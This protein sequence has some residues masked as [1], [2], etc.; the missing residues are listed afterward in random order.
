MTDADGCVHDLALRWVVEDGLIQEEDRYQDVETFRRCASDGL[1]TGWWSGLGLPGP[2]DR[3]VTGFLR[4]PTGREIPVHNGT[5]RLQDL[6]QWGLQR[7]AAAG[8]VE[9]DSV[10]FEPSRSCV[11]VSGRVGDA[12]GARDLFIC[13]V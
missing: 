1:P 9:L 13:M 4:T 3:V 10:T 8:L 12:G 11:G 2:S 7:F 5:A 6:V